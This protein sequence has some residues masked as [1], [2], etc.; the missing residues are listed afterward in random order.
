MWLAC[1]PEDGKRLESGQPVSQGYQSV[2][3]KE[4][5]ENEQNRCQHTSSGEQQRTKAQRQRNAIIS[6]CSE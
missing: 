2:S 1:C 5:R 3:G 4:M 6:S